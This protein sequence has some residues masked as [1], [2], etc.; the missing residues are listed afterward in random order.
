MS[1][2]VVGLITVVILL[3][4]RTRAR[5]ACNFSKGWKSVANPAKSIQL[6]NGGGRAIPTE[7]CSLEQGYCLTFLSLHPNSYYLSILA[8]DTNSSQMNVSALIWTANQN[9]P[10]LQ[11]S[12]LE[13]GKDGDLV[14]RSPEG[15]T[16]WSAN[17]SGLD[18]EIVTLSLCEGDLRLV[19]ADND[20]VWSSLENPT[21]TLITGQLLDPGK[22]LKSSVSS[23]VLAEGNY[24]LVVKKCGIVLF[25]NHSS[26]SMP[27]WIWAMDGANDLAS[28][29]SDDCEFGGLMMENVSFSLL[30]S[31]HI[32][33]APNSTPIDINPLSPRISFS[34]SESD[35]SAYTYLKLDSNGVLKASS[36]TS[37]WADVFELDKYLEDPC[38]SPKHCNSYGVCTNS[39]CSCPSS[40]FVPTSSTTPDDGCRSR[41]T[42]EPNCTGK[43][44]MLRLSGIDYFPN[45]YAKALKLSEDDCS[46][47][48]LEDCSCVAAFYWSDSGSCFHV[49]ESLL[50]LKNTGEKTRT[51]YLKIQLDRHSGSKISYT[52]L[53]IG[54]SSAVAALVFILLGIRHRLR[55][56][57]SADLTTAEVEEEFKDYRP[58]G[59]FKRFNLK[60][61]QRATEGFGQKIGEG[62][63]GRVYVGTIEGNKKIAVKR[64]ECSRQGK[65]GFRAEIESLGNIQHVNLVH[66][67]GFCAEGNELL[68][69]YEYVVNGSLDRWIFRERN[70]SCNT[71]LGWERRWK[72]ANGVA[73]G[74]AYLHEQCRKCILHLDIKPQN[75]LLDENLDAKISDFGLSCL[76]SSEQSR[77][78]TTLRG[79]P[80]YLAPEWL[81]ETGISSKS[82]VY[83]L[84][85]V[86]LELVSGRKNVEVSVEEERRH[87][88]SWAWRKI[89]E[90]GWSSV[91]E[92]VDPR[93]HGDYD[94]EEVE[95]MLNLAFKCVQRESS[96][97]PSMGEVVQILE[98]KMEG[99]VLM[100]R[101]F[102]FDR[103]EQEVT[104]VENNGFSGPALSSV[105]DQGR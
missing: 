29:D 63:F 9:N 86:L 60:E 64:V 13:F 58:R 28:V 12:T 73:H 41:V 15:L 4:W 71:P 84:G 53:G 33:S 56:K 90:K 65:K 45:K 43:Q 51:A 85:M 16:V 88:P 70:G 20:T 97:R 34:N 19:D 6:N 17:N 40:D 5:A 76:M 27:Y 24:S 54:L 87:Y 104:T 26:M 57:R 82:D 37:G 77:L 94:E 55:N 8:F 22:R 39:Q 105:V 74:L 30:R 98:R 52:G 72:I 48:C 23:T 89:Q 36:F 91:K 35:L 69:V 21:D 83:S 7:A 25:Y 79:T 61:L 44:K 10:V 93:L 95:I 75:I 99:G 96:S 68:L 31:S 100:N 81:L 38:F 103:E 67:L 2:F 101:V 46:G 62:G 47:S 78:E 102:A 42:L 80:G 1:K 3:E 66:L 14:L 59:L 11:N 32:I 50:S 18:V 92:L 49:W